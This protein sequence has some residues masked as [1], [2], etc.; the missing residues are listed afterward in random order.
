MSTPLPWGQKQKAPAAAAAAAAAPAANAW[1]RGQKVV[2]K[3]PAAPSAGSSA[4][5]SSASSAGAPVP[6]PA[7][8][9]MNQATKEY[10]AQ[11]Y[12]AFNNGLV[13]D[14][15]RLYAHG[16]KEQSKMYYRDAPWPSENAIA[17]LCDGSQL[18][19]MLYK[20]LCFRHLYDIKR[21]GVL[22]R[23]AA[24]EHYCK[25]FDFV[26]EYGYDFPYVLPLEWLFDLISEFVYQFQAFWQFHAKIDR[27]TEE[28]VHFLQENPNAWS[29]ATV[30][31]YLDQLQST[32]LIREAIVAERAGTALPQLPG[33]VLHYLGYMSMV[34]EARLQLMIGDYH[35]SLKAIE[36]IDISSEARGTGLFTRVP[37]CRVM[38]YYCAG[39]AS[40]M[41]RRFPAAGS[42]LNQILM[43]LERG[44]DNRNGMHGSTINKKKEQMYCLLTLM[45]CVAPGLDVDPQV[46]RRLEQKCGEKAARVRR[47]DDSA[48][49]ELFDYGS[50]AFV[51]AHA[52]DYSN[53]TDHNQFAKRQQ[54]VPFLNEIKSRRNISKISSSVKFYTTVTI[55]KLAELL[56]T[57]PDEL[58]DRL[59]FIKHKTLYRGEPSAEGAAAANGKE[60]GMTGADG[61]TWESVNDAHFYIK[62][63]TVI[64][65]APA[66]NEQ[67]RLGN[68]SSGDY[69]VRNISRFENIIQNIKKDWE[70]M[71]KPMG[72]RGKR[73]QGKGGRGGRG[74][75]RG[76]RG[77]GRGG[78]RRNNGGRRSGGGGRRDNNRN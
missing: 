27:R 76:G 31:D 42:L 25:L 50:P 71:P 10:V 35:S 74:G 47:G 78:G 59:T 44:N 7:D 11:L 22:E 38:L 66:T 28:D 4:S 18:F 3:Q 75:R 21:A 32:S 17:P 54:S 64:V 8:Y 63:D 14:L 65:S 19:Q 45:R 29:P 12:H 41:L 49:D 16:W 2:V 30:I 69:F 43:S 46:A 1:A 37:L 51:T 61:A 6:V 33:Q 72:N 15:K 58:R 20:E 70:G 53:I 68:D 5:S 39:F 26:L 40:M 56:D 62:D 48:F 13:P 24:F 36:V 73:G 52:P 60:N 57:T 77:G 67:E 23:V 9:M 34:G 55:T